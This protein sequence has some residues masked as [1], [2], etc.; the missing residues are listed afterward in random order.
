VIRSA[1]SMIELVFAIVIMGI[2]VM[3]LPLVLLQTQRG[4]ALALEQ[5][6]ILATKTRLAFIFSHEWDVNSYDST[7]GVS[8]VLDT[9]ASANADNAF[10]TTT[11]RRAGHIEADERRRLRDDKLTPTLKSGIDW[12]A[13]IPTDIDDFDGK[14]SNVNVIA[15]DMDYIYSIS[16]T[17]KIEYISDAL[18]NGSF[19]ASSS[20][21]T[22]TFNPTNTQANPTNIKMISVTSSGSDANVTLRAF[23]SNIGES[24]ILK[25]SSW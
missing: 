8:R 5:E 18:E 17:S 9:T 16:L 22:F 11:T 10:D 14:T 25:R 1:M 15:A 2:V 19:Y 23:A 4:N 6:V 20:G 13:T 3:S 12:N 7:A 24:G 21:I